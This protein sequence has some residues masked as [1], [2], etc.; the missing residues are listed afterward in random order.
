MSQQLL[1]IYLPLLTPIVTFAIVMVGFLY[2]NSRLSD[3]RSGIGD[4]RSE[5]GGLRT[6]LRGNIENLRIEL[7]GNIE[8]LRTEFR[9]DVEDLRTELRGSVGDLRGSIGDIRGSMNDM[10]DM[11]RAEMRV[12][13]TTMEKNHS[14]L[15]GKFADL[16]TRVSHIEERFH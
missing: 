9:G 2:N 14:E 12:V 1:A 10:R 15:L 16:D 4:L 8:N 6:E 13:Q 3:F 11:L 5:F 7:R